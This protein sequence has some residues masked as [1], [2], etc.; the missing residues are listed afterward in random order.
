MPKAQNSSQRTQRMRDF[1]ASGATLQEVAERFGLSRERVRQIF[2]QADVP[3]RSIAETY[4]LK[5][6]RLVNDRSAEIC[7]AFEKTKDIDEVAHR[8]KISRTV[9]KEVILHR[10]SESERRRP[11]KVRPTYSNEELIAFLREAD[12]QADKPLSIAAYSEYAAARRTP[13]GRSW[14][15]HQTITKRLGGTW[16]AAA[17][18]AGIAMSRPPRATMPQAFD[19]EQCAGALRIAARELAK[20]PTANEYDRFARASHGA[21]PSV[22]TVRNRLGTWYE[23]LIS[24]GL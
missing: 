10:F 8:L 19:E 13:D 17:Q 12:A 2:G 6:A 16:R 4:A 14:P 22:A 20:V 9:V 18:A 24:A 21:L 11:R 7:A 5:R 1:Y 23:A 15:T 3:I